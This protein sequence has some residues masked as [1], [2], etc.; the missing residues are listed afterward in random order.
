MNVVVSFPMPKVKY[1]P[2]VKVMQVYCA[3]FGKNGRI[4]R[5]VPTNQGGEIGFECR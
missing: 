1:Q 5:M 2:A 3:Q 4:I